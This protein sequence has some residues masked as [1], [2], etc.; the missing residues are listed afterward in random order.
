MCDYSLDS[1]PCCGRLTCKFFDIPPN[2][3]LGLC[4]LSLSLGQLHDFLSNKIQQKYHHDSF[5]DVALRD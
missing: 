4:S 5:Y 1:H 3:K 2:K